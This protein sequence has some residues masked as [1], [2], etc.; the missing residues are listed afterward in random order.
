MLGGRYGWWLA[1][2]PFTLGV[3]QVNPLGLSPAPWLIAI[4]VVLAAILLARLYRMEEARTRSGDEQPLFSMK[5]FDNR[6]FFTSWSAALLGFILAGA[7][8]FMIPVF[9]QQA[10]GF[11]SLQSAI[12]MIIFSLGSIILGFASGKLLEMMQA[13][14]LMQVFLLV[15][16]LGLAWLAFAA[17]VNMTLGSFVLPMFIIG[18]GWGVISSQIP[19]IQLSTLSPELQGEGSGFAETGKELGIGLGTAVIGSIMFSMAVGGFVDTVARQTN[20]PLTVQERAETILM[21]E[22]EALPEEAIE[23]VRQ[24][25]PN[26][27]QLGNEAFVEGFQIAL[28]VLVA[29]VLLSL[30]VASFIPKVDSERVTAEETKELVADVSSKRL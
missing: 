9:T 22:D 7:I 28:G 2:R 14:T 3:T 12:V 1:R 21:I 29:I 8:P 15:V 27:E 19:N 26:L 23:A 18:A 30:L 11:D 17:D 25:V 5:L 10:L 6:T 24:Q 13:R 4:G 16:A 20:I